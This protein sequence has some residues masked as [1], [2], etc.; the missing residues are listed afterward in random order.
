ML[1]VPR[2][3]AQRTSYNADLLFPGLRLETHA[4]T[5][6]YEEIHTVYDIWK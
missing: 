4:I 3:L 1:N 6:V 5:I 2:V